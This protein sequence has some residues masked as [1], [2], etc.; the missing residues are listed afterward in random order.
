MATYPQLVVELT[1]G[2][3]TKNVSFTNPNPNPDDSK[4]RSLGRELADAY[5]NGY[6]FVQ[7]S[8]ITDSVVATND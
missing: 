4:I 6:A 1:D 8:Y 5:G 2:T 3:S 7:G